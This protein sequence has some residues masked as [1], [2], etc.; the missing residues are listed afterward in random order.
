VNLIK[1]IAFALTPPIMQLYVVRRRVGGAWTTYP[2]RYC[3]GMMLHTNY[4]W[5]KKHNGYVMGK[6]TAE[7]V[8]GELNQYGPWN[9]WHVVERVR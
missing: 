2:V 3:P 5:S 1:R 9:T 7:F 6:S 8:A 4:R